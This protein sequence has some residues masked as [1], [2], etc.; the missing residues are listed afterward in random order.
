MVSVRGE[1]RRTVAPDYA[2]FQ[3][4]LRGG[5][6]SQAEALAAVRQ[7]QDAIVGALEQLGGV[8]LTAQTGRARLTWS[9]GTMNTRRGRKFDKATGR[10]TPT[11]R[12]RANAALLVVARDFA[13]L[14]PV[15]QA[16]AQQDRLR[17][18]GIGWSVDDDNPAWPVV[19]ADA[20]AAA[21]TKGSDYA[22]ALGGSIDSVEHIA[23]A[24]L[25]SGEPS[26]FPMPLHAGWQADTL[27]GTGG[28][29]GPS[30]TPVPQ[31]LSA[32]IEARLV[33]EVPALTSNAT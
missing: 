20:I 29:G 31:E 27:S 1:A 13:L 22:A 23:D 21:I 9:V 17:I 14:D 5:G 19:R 10:S 25:L 26:R 12:I 15:R 30:L 2:S 11:G 7:T 3:C 33:A 28:T 16:L 8:A 24:G 32:V 4:G 18:H 6:R